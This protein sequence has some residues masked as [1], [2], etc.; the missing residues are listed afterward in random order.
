[1][2]QIIKDFVLEKNWG[3]I[4]SDSNSSLQY[5]WTQELSTI[6]IKNSTKYISL[7]IR[8]YNGTILFKR[9]TL[10]ILIDDIFHNEYIFTDNIP[11]IDVKLN[12]KDKTSISF[13]TTDSFC[14]SKIEKSS[15]DNRL[16]GFKIYAITVELDNNTDTLI[17]INRLLVEQEESQFI[18]SSKYTYTIARLSVKTDMPIIHYTGQYGTSGYA[19]AAKGYLY[20]Y[21]MN[22]YKIKW[23]PLKFDETYLSKD[24]PYNIVA[25]S[26]IDR[27]YSNY[28]T[29]IYHSTPDVWP[30]LN[31]EFRKINKNKLKVGYTVWET[32]KLP[33]N[34]VNH[35]NDEVHEVWCPSLY[36][37]KV[38]KDSGVIIPIKVVPHIF[39]KKQLIDKSK[40]ELYSVDGQLLKNDDIY[41]FYTI[42]EFNTRKG[43]DD[44]I[45]VFCETFTRND[46]VRLIIKT[47]YKNYNPSNR[48]YCM[49]KINAII[50]QYPNPPKIYCILDNVSESDILGIHS[51][52][53]CYISLTKSE[54][55]GMTIFDAFNYGKQIITTGYSGHMDFLSNDYNGLVKFKLDYV[56]NMKTFSENYSEDTLW[57]YPDLDHVSELMKGMVK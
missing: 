9:R 10:K 57:A 26:L 46:A 51:L 22:N 13:V 44:T 17:P 47:H 20:R 33:K 16:L 4:E 56:R 1:M 43:I 42:G 50:K 31:E 35:I 14:P 30:M 11:Y 39:L 3:T 41:T 36:N 21:F 32:D 34:W 27:N 54:G 29:F 37:M 25:E 55:F 52:G 23:T 7:K 8:I 53:D 2:E 5:R 40:I 19:T 38:F 15:P 6:Y 45:K 28:D 24:C 49:D 12:I 18:D 48:Q